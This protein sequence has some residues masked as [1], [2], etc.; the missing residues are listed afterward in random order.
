VYFQSSTLSTSTTPSSRPRD[1]NWPVR[2]LY[3]GSKGIFST[4]YW[5]PAPPPPP[6][7]MIWTDQSGNFTSGQKVYSVQYTVHQHHSLLPPPWNELTSL[8]ALN[9]VK[10]HMQYSM[11]ST[12]LRPPS[13][14]P[15]ELNRAVFKQI[16]AEDFRSVDLKSEDAIGQA[17][18]P[19][20]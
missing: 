2:Q 12:S 9:E 4:V 6:A 17:V 16:A 5:A 14:P 15:N 10:G 3:M 1:M 20:Q 11:Q 13:S 18:R 19:D 7:L 8:A